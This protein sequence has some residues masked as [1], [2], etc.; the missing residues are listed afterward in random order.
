MV[1]L[2]VAEGCYYCYYLLYQLGT[3]GCTQKAE[4]VRSVYPGCTKSVKLLM[5]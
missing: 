2:M 1:D 5:F 4:P 3:G